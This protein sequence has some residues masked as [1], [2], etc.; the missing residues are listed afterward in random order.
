MT[1]SRNSSDGSVHAW[2]I[3]TRSNYADSFCQ[4]HPPLFAL[5]TRYSLST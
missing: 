2:R 4:L 5:K 1:Y 3:S